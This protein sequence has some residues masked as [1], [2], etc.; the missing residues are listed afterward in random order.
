MQKHFL[1]IIIIVLLTGTGFPQ[2]LERP[3]KQASLISEIV[4]QIDKAT[5]WTLQNNGAWISAQNKIPFKEYSLNRISKG[6]YLLGI[7]NFTSIEIRQVIVLDQ[8]YSILIVK[9]LDGNYE[10]PILEQNWTGF[11]ALKYYVFNQNRWNKI[12]PASP[13][14]NQPYAVNMNLLCSGIMPNYNEKTYLFEI[15]NQI[16]KAVF[17]RE[18]S[19]SN[20]IFAVYPIE[21]GDE[22]IVRFKFYETLN[23]KEL[24]VKYL[25]NYNWEKLFKS[26][27]Y[28]IKFTDLKS[29]IDDIFVIDPKRLA[30][31]NYYITFLEGGIRNFKKEKY[32]TASQNF[33][34]ALMVH[35][36]DTAKN[37]ILLWRGKAYQI[38]K[39]FDNAKADF[40]TIIN[41]STVTYPNSELLKQV[42][43][44]RGSCNY[45]LY[46]YNQACKDWQRAAELGSE[47]AMKSL[48]KNCG[49]NGDSTVVLSDQNKANHY[50]E[51]AM[52]KY[53]DGKYL[54]SL[55]LFEDAW[56][57]NPE[58]NDFRIPYY[59][60]VCRYNTNDFVRAIDD[61]EKAIGMKPDE[62]SKDFD[63]WID[64]F[65]MRGRAWQSINY[66]WQACS[67]WQKARQLGSIDVLEFIDKYC[68][69]SQETPVQTP[70]SIVP[71]KQ[72][73]TGIISFE[74]GDFEKSI[75]ALTAALENCTEEESFTIYNF[76]ASA[77][78]KIHD[79]QGAVADF[80]KAIEKRPSNQKYFTD[81]YRSWF[82]RGIS[83]YFMS[84]YKGACADW[85]QAIEMGL[86][87]IE[88]LYYYNNY[89]EE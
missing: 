77:K 30:D 47:Q 72:L 41:D 27:Y 57:Y 12:L 28:E 7:E 69:K 87:D 6:R 64:A 10:F 37:S 78:H 53:V 59:I 3:K 51:M 24:Y 86:E 16:Q 9:Y 54:K 50:F 66:D 46:D 70:I 49:K 11:E 15:E 75:T 82:N 56:K 40:N 17:Q 62:S 22:K 1:I 35:P 8:I 52:E 76:R 39:L 18:V 44:L 79:Y 32:V 21:I 2:Q 83:K 25:L 68:T 80:S 81:W 61:F 88:A 42:Y 23:K 19:V 89:C 14:F 34:K 65:V 5:G 33:T 60:G 63:L 85:Q 38:L 36:P 4:S 48:K 20:M 55:F 29:F 58:H 84:D 45:S 71:N 67:D 31:V 26:H 13:E 74:N 73:E 43:H